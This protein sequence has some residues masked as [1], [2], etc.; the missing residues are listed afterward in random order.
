MY[1][2]YRDHHIFVCL[3][4]VW[5][6]DLKSDHDENPDEL[7]EEKLDAKEWESD[8]DDN[9]V[10]ADLSQQMPD[11]SSNFQSDEEEADED[12]E[13]GDDESDPLLLNREESKMNSP[14][15]F[16]PM[17]DDQT[18]QALRVLIATPEAV[19]NE[20]EHLRTA[21][22]RAT[23]SSSTTSDI[24]ISGKDKQMVAQVVQR[25]LLGGDQLSR[26]RAACAMMTNSWHADEKKALLGTQP[27]LEDFHMV[28]SCL[29]VIFLRDHV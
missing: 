27:V 8:R 28:S 29:S 7:S 3:V 5:P 22:K 1:R 13:D 20:V 12:N 2:L 23:S 16:A 4:G 9:D 26:L 10:D 19:P 24:S 6:S 25:I 11:S 15:P 14:K 18:L 17:S 21:L